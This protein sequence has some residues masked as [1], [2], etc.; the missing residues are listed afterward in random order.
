M[1]GKPDRLSAGAGKWSGR[2][3]TERPMGHEMDGV[4]M[5][6]PIYW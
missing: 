1:A 4:Y 3:G 6:M 2:R 5:F